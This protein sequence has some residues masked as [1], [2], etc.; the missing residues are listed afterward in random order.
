MPETYKCI[1]TYIAIDANAIFKLE[2]PADFLK[3]DIPSLKYKMWDLGLRLGLI[4]F[5][6]I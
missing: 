6:I 5:G 3:I 4:L 1:T 2:L